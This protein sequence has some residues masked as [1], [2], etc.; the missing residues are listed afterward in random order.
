[1]DPTRQVASAY[2]VIR[3]RRRHF[4]SESTRKVASVIERRLYKD[5]Y[6]EELEVA[7]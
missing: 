3:R 7:K 5:E 4:Y 1:M 6:A 2:I